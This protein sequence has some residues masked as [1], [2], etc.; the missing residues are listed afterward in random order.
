M[1]TP[2]DHLLDAHGQIKSD[3]IEDL[4]VEVVSGKS[5]FESAGILYASRSPTLVEQDTARIVYTRRLHRC[6]QD[7]LPTRESLEAMALEKGIF[8]PAERQE[9]KNLETMIQKL[10]RARESTTDPRQKVELAA[11]VDRIH[12]RHVELRMPEEE[13]FLHS[14]EAKAEESRVGYMVSQ[15]TLTGDLLDKPLWASWE[16]FQLST[17]VT[18]MTDARR[19][20]MRAW[21][22]LPIK[23]IRAIARSN[24]WRGRWKASKETG[25]PVFDGVPTSWD[26]N[27]RNL[28]W[29]TDFYDAVY[30]HPEC[31]AEDTIQNDDS[32]QQWMNQQVAKSKRVKPMA[33]PTGRSYMTGDGKRV[34]MIKVGQETI[35]VNTPTKVRR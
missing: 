4:L 23:I 5:I 13:V 6:K 25:A 19:A 24:E 21:Q 2:Y 32:L 33:E 9:T 30:R 17:Q 28:A 14:A 27:K 29:W 26:I 8:D 3:L 7:G 11:E 18:L 22:G 15:C 1:I 12:A 16:T 35:E 20:F 31:P 34:P 10:V